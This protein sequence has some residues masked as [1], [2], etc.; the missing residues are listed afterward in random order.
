MYCQKG[1]NSPPPHLPAPKVAT[2]P[3]AS[4]TAVG[5][6]Q[7]KSGTENPSGEYKTKQKKKVLIRS[8]SIPREM[9]TEGEPE[10]RGAGLPLS[11][12]AYY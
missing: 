4:D 9:G 11:A 7:H 8:V 1:A 10:D 12:A 6:L 2:T 5:Q 3:F